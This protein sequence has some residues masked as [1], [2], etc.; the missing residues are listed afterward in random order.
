VV[1]TGLETDRT[2]DDLSRRDIH[3]EWLGDAWFE[4]SKLFG[5][6]PWRQ[7]LMRMMFPFET[8]RV[9]KVIVGVGSALVDILTR[10]N[11][12]F[13]EKTGAVKG[14]M[15]YVEREHIEKTL[16]LSS[17]APTIVPGGSACNTVVGVSKLGGHSRFVGKCGPG[18]MGNFFENALRTQQVEP[19]LSRSNTPTGRVLSIITP[20]AERSMFTFLGAASE[21]RPEDIPDD[22]FT[23][24]AVVHIEGY[25]LYNP[26]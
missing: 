14:G 5:C 20:D 25:L 19:R 7:E 3:T 22:A 21:T 24:A 4:C 26:D 11:D 15:V 6:K 9:K 23:D 8:Q 2:S 12:E 13:L 16:S 1:T 18:A 10:E 17:S